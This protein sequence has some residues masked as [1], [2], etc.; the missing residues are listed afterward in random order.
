VAH[1]KAIEGSPR[2][3]YRT[4]RS[5]GQHDHLL[6]VGIGL[7][8]VLPFY[9]EPSSLIGNDE[10][11]FAAK[12]LAMDEPRE[13][14]NT[15]ER[16]KKTPVVRCVPSS[17]LRDVVHVRHFPLVRSKT[18]DTFYGQSEL[19]VR[20]DLAVFATCGIPG[21]PSPSLHLVIVLP[22]FH[23]FKQQKPVNLELLLLAHAPIDGRRLC[24]SEGR[25]LTCH[26]N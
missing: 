3:G 6:L 22:L 24:S 19:F 2:I 26:G 23:Q 5:K 18:T 14:R 1:I 12:T 11:P 8:A 25:G 17:P 4:S 16:L 9:V 13:S 15:C 10:V 21:R 20:D 7:Q